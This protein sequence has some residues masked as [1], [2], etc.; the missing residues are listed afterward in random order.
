LFS[1]LIVIASPRANANDHAQPEHLITIKGS[2][3]TFRIGHL[4]TILR[5]H[6]YR[7]QIKHKGEVHAGDHESVIDQVLW[8]KAQAQLASN[9]AIRRSGKPSKAPSLL[10]GL[11]FDGKGN[12]MT[13]SHAVKNGKRYRYYISNNLIAG[14]NKSRASDPGEGLCAVCT[15]H[16]RGDPRRG[17]ADRFESRSAHQPLAAYRLG[18]ATVGSRL[19]IARRHAFASRQTAKAE[20]F[21]LTSQQKPMHSARECQSKTRLGSKTAQTTLGDRNCGPFTGACRTTRCPCL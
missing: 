9:A 18:R 13:P 14:A 21:A 12:R 4:Y 7:G 10:A 20:E 8:D 15:G 17:P 11:L 19:Q 6:L 3:F 16:R 5:N 1:Y 2:S